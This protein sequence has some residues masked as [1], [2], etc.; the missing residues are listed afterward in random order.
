MS[1]SLKN[2]FISFFSVDPF[3]SPER[4]IGQIL[5]SYFLDDKT[6]VSKD[7]VTCPKLCGH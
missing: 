2:A 7:E 5:L 3:S 6:K 1:S 4:Y